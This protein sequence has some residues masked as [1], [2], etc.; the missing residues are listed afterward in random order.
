MFYFL[1]IF[2]TQ[3]LRA[4]R[5]PQYVPMPGYLSQYSDWNTGF[6]FW[7][8]QVSRLVLA[9]GKIP[10]IKWPEHEATKVRNE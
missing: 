3:T 6:D 5:F 2:H 10:E 1:Q 8:R 9:V 7:R 4:I